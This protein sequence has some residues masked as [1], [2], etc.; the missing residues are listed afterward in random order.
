MKVI[1]ASGLS[2]IHEIR[3]TILSARMDGGI[4]EYR[5]A[6]RSRTLVI[7]RWTNRVEPQSDLAPNQRG[8]LRYNEQT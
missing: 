3:R 6:V 4:N 7:N 8:V 5:I 2:N 1:Y